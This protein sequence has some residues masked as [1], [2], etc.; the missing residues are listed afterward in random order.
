MSIGG[1]EG[2][3]GGGSIHS[4]TR[5]KTHP[6]TTG[7]LPMTPNKEYR[8]P[9]IT[10]RC[11]FLTVTLAI[12]AMAS[13][14]MTLALMTDYWEYVDFDH[15]EVNELAGND[16]TVEWLLNNTV[17]RLSSPTTDKSALTSTT[18]RPTLPDAAGRTGGKFAFV[19][20]N[21]HS[22][23]SSSNRAKRDV[24]TFYL[25]PMYGGVWATCTN[26]KGTSTR[27]PCP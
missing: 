11:I 4:S 25:V 15:S 14:L 26:L 17:A 21:N 24:K 10:A 23:S 8:P 27:T 5:Q 13:G 2:R 1:G 19:N 9:R 18:S 20:R 6:T 7:S 12:T 16:T 3:R 22:E